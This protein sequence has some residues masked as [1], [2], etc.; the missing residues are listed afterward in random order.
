[1]TTAL[2]ARAATIDPMSADHPGQL[3]TRPEAARVLPRYVG[4]V[5][6]T[7]G[8]R[9]YGWDVDVDEALPLGTIHVQPAAVRITVAEVGDLELALT[10]AEQRRQAARFLRNLVVRTALEVGLT[11]LRPFA[12]PVGA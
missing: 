8:V 4:P 1:M 11:D 5:L 2:A 12:R 6:V 10:Y 7:A 3:L 9:A